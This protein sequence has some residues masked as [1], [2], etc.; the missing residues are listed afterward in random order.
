MKE[1]RLKGR[2]P[3][4]LTRCPGCGRHI[5]PQ[6]QACPLCGGQLVVLRNKQLKAL[7]SAHA[8][9]ASLRSILGE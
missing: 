1:A 7:T 5:Y 6:A 2:L 9:L 3:P 4:Q 8:A